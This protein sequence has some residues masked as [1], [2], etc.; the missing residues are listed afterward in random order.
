M[1]SS[2]A[3]VF[4]SWKWIWNFLGGSLARPLLQ[5]R[6]MAPLCSQRSQDHPRRRLLVLFCPQQDTLGSDTFCVICG[7]SQTLSQI[8]SVL[9]GV[10]HSPSNGLCPSLSVYGMKERITGKAVKFKLLQEKRRGKLAHTHHRELTISSSR[11]KGR[12]LGW[13]VWSH[14]EL[15][16]EPD[17]AAAKLR[18][19]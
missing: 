5:K 12:N 8:T 3:L 10:S 9:K 19:T 7:M 11:E 14:L 16:F 1:S 18:M 2:D 13:C 17:I 4:P 15:S 6:Q